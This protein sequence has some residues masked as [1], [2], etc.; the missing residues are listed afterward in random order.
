MLNTSSVFYPNKTD[1]CRG[2]E[3]VSDFFIKNEIF[4]ALVLNTGI[5][6][7]IC[8]FVFIKL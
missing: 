6:N 5:K 8:I 1:F 7:E 3:R 2:I 4:Y